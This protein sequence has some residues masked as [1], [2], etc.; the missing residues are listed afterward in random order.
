MQ[1]FLQKTFFHFHVKIV[2]N[3]LSLFVESSG[4]VNLD[5]EMNF[6]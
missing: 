5:D 4:F 3:T 2:Q 6:L 1:R